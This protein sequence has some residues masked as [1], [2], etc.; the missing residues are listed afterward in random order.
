MSSPAKVSKLRPDVHVMDLT[1][2]EVHLELTQLLHGAGD[3][4]ARLLLELARRFVR[5][6]QAEYGCVDLSKPRDYLREAKEESMDRVFYDMVGEYQ[7][8]SK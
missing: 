4:E 8:R 5:F 2:A 7:R 3:I 1:T 6:G